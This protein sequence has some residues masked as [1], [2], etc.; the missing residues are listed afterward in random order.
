MVF[1]ILRMHAVDLVFFKNPGTSKSSDIK[2]EGIGIQIPK[3]CGGSE[4]R[5]RRRKTIEPQKR[6]AGANVAT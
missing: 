5:A 3:H 4:K 1:S 6:P 2:E